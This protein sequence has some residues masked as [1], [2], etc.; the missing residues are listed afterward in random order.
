MEAINGDGPT[1]A[2]INGSQI[3]FESL[4]RLEPQADTSY[5]IHVKGITPGD[6]RIQIQLVSDDFQ[7]PVT[8]E[9]STHVYADE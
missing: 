3:V 2:T 6:K 8:K 7:E 1:R 5:S 9:E 4:P